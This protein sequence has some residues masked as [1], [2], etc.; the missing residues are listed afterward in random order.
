M[1]LSIV[2]PAF[3]DQAW[4]DGACKLGEACARS[5]GECT[6]DQLRMRLSRGD[7]TLLCVR[8]GEAAP[9]AWVAVQFDQHPNLRALFIYAIWA[10]GA[11][12]DEAFALLAQYGRDGGASV[13]R[14]ACDEAIARLWARKFGFKSVYQIM[15]VTL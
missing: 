12:S 8:E 10:P 5:A 15:G 14:G 1:Q 13:L 7:L 9:V 6:P 3:I 4:R 2:N 11:T